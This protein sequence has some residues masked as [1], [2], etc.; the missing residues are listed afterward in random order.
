MKIVLYVVLSVIIGG[1][2][3]YPIAAYFLFKKFFGR[4]KQEKID[5]WDLSD[6]HYEP[7]RKKIK[8]SKEKMR[9]EE[10]EEVFITSSDNL[11]LFAR[12]YPR[13]EKVALLAH[14]MHSDPFNNFSVIMQSFLNRGYGILM[15][16]QRA[17]GKSEGKYSSYG[18]NE[19]KDL[20]LWTD[21]LDKK[22]EI[23]SVTI[24]GV[25]MGATAALYAS[26]KID[27]EKINAIIADCGFNSYKDLIYNNAN[28]PSLPVAM[29]FK[30]FSRFAE[31]ITGAKL[32]AENTLFS[33]KNARV[34][35]LFLHG[36]EDKIVSRKSSEAAYNACGSEKKLLIVS[37]AGHTT[38]FVAGGEKIEEE[39]F[40]FIKKATP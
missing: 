10:Y 38:A 33:V 34:K 28:I 4:I 9:R 21:Y 37:G 3:S 23:K 31:K 35:I 25:S 6:E 12:Y 11:K 27:S 26:D 8:L 1:V 2:I 39:I 22:H 15:P 18:V 16:D 5:E 30:P 14:G 7:F 40:G 29:F 32:S 24:Y 20:L 13:G 19:S 36:A 17:H